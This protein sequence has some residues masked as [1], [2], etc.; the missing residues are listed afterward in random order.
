MPEPA[1]K[2]A[3]KAHIALFLPTLFA[4]GVERVMLNLASGFLSRGYS[5][6]LVA[7]NAAGQF[8]DQ[9]PPQSRLIDLKARRVLTSIPAL[10]RYLRAE[11][12]DA[13]IAGMTH[14]SI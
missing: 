9:V 2:A 11:Q 7:A 10:A 6:D 1:S 4:G 3:N 14:S 5:L 12:P 8:R 13:L